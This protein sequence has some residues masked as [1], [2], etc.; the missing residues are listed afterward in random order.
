[1]RLTPGLR[2]A[3]ATND[4][5]V[6]VDRLINR[7]IGERSVFEAAKRLP[8]QGDRIFTA[9]GDAY[10]VTHPGGGREYELR[11]PYGES[12]SINTVVAGLATGI[13]PPV[14]ITTP[15]IGSNGVA[16]GNGNGVAYYTGSTA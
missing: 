6:V 7:W 16:Y 12:I 10:V 15:V 13:T 3:E 2:R 5:G 14:V 11:D 4:A 9:G 1:M 8:K